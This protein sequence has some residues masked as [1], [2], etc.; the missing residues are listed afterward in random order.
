VDGF[1]VRRQWPDGSHD[2]FRFSR[3]PGPAQDAIE[4]DR[5]YWRKGPVAPVG[6][7]VVAISSRDF[8]L[9]RGRR[10]CRAPDCP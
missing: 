3:T 8:E 7:R 6:H 2:Y 1:A 10:R 5:R 9:H 4:A